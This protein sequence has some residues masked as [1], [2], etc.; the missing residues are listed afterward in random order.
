[1]DI[2]DLESIPGL[3]TDLDRFVGSSPEINLVSFLGGEEFHMAEYRRLILDY[4]GCLIRF[5]TIRP[6]CEN[7]RMDRVRRF[8]T[9]LFM[10][11][12][13]EVC[14]AQLDNDVQVEV[15]ET[16]DQGC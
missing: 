7:P 16:H 12:A 5:S 11:Q 9:L 14:L 4:A 13:R 8:I 2:P 3:A 1:M 6:L 10:E 15:Y